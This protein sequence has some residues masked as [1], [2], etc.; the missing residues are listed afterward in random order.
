VPLV[1][2]RRDWCLDNDQTADLYRSTRTSL[3]LY[4]REHEDREHSCADGWAIG[5]REVELAA[6]GTFFLRDSRPEGNALF[7]WLPVF[8]EPAE[9][10]PLLDWW[11]AHDAERERVT[12][13]ARDAIQHRTFGNNA[14]WLLQHLT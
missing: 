6:C 10:R 9:V 14:K 13:R 2:H 8:T 11:L 1:A 7:P 3:N 5:P 12:A 4:R